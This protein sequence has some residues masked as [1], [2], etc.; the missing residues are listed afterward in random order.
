MLEL[1]GKEKGAGGEGKG[2]WER[3][4]RKGMVRK[5]RNGVAGKG[6]KGMC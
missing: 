4:G 2:L 5:G 1:M 6:R 3:E